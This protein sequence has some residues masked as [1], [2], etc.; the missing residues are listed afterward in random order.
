L[1]RKKRILIS[2]L[3]CILISTSCLNSFNVKAAE[4]I[5]FNR[6][7]GINRYYTN[8][9]IADNGWSTTSKYAVL[10]TG[11]DFPDSLSAV[12]LAKKYSAP[13]L[14]TTPNTLPTVIENKIDSLHV[15]TIF[16]VGGVGV[17]SSTIENKLKNKGI[18]C[19]R[20]AGINRY[21]TSL[22]IAKYLNNSGQVFLATGE[23]F[24]DALSIASYAANKQIPILLTLKDTMPQQVKNYIKDNNINKVY[25]IGGSGVISDQVIS[26]LPGVERLAG[27]DRY[28]TNRNILNKFSN[29]ISFE[30]TCLATG[31]NFPD[32]IS[33]AALAS[34]TN[35]PIV[36]VDSD[37]DL[38]SVRFMKAKKSSIKTVKTFGGSGVIPE[39]VINRFFLNDEFISA[40][41]YYNK[42]MQFSVNDLNA[43]KYLTLG[44]SCYPYDS[45]L[46][47]ENNK[48]STQILK[49]L[50]LKHNNDR[51]DEAI[52]GYTALLNSAVPSYVKTEARVCKLLAEEKTHVI[53]KYNFLPSYANCAATGLSY[54]KSWNVKY[55]DNLTYEPLGNYFNFS[56]TRCYHLDANTKFDA[57]GVPLVKFNDK[58]YYNPVSICQYAL[59]QHG[60]LLNGEDTKQSIINCANFI[61]SF[62]KEDGSLRYDIDY[63]HYQSLGLGWTSSMAQGQ[64][65]SLF[66][67]A[68]T[69]TKDPKYIQAG[70]KA[71]SYLLKPV[72]A[73]GVMDTL[74]SLDPSLK[75]YVFFQEYVTTPATYTLNGFIYTLVGLYDWSCLPTGVNTE[76]S[77]LAG[78]YFNGGVSTL[79]VVLPYYDLGGFTSYDLMFITSNRIPTTADFYHSVHIEQLDVVYYITKD[80]F[81]NN[82]R[83]LWKSYVPN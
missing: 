4:N 6:L 53:P 64:A 17:V 32:A 79:K 10:A 8:L 18:N 66:A 16:I 31:A 7:A 23:D 2:F 22:Q 39:C 44:L 54:Y 29:E 47:I 9:Q 76:K 1:K 68:Y 24:P 30:T 48:R 41:D 60:K 55:T 78:Q 27:I 12:P 14:L 50:R 73:G 77:N 20:L 65:L 45:G 25:V 19:I 61:A 58:F 43:L 3:V 13:I 28:D 42:V 38:N 51:Y 63:Y 37:A 15:E 69:L 71:L 33:G 56:S 70:N 83:D 34:M 74:E 67:R 62:L 52:A 36:L 75:N 80:P 57:N 49:E 40:A 72:S 21:E 59:S 82:L 81:F 11:E 5:A 26:S 35:S 46:N